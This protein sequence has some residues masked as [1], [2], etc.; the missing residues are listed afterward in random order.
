MFQETHASKKT[1]WRLFQW[2]SLGVLSW[3]GTSYLPYVQNAK[4]K[5]KSFFGFSLF[6]GQMSKS[7]VSLK[8]AGWSTVNLVSI[9]PK[10]LWPG[11]AQITSERLFLSLSRSP[12][13]LHNT[14]YNA[15]VHYVCNLSLQYPSPSPP[16]PSSMTAIMSLSPTTPVSALQVF[17]M[18]CET[19]EY[20]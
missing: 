10:H 5:L 15:H 17:N 9:S 2:I 4:L 16:D 12:P 18:Y 8:R 19:N 20:S 7:S 13:V 14:L 6:L 3:V 11:S 1:L